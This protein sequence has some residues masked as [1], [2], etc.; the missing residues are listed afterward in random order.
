M[1]ASHPWRRWL[2]ALTMAATLTASVAVETAA[3]ATALPA[4]TVGDTYT[5]RRLYVDW[6]HSM[7]DT[8]YRLSAIYYPTDMVSTSNAGLSASYKVRKFV[9]RGSQGDGH[10]REGRR[11][12]VQHPVR[13]PQLRHAE[14]HVRLL[15][16]APWLRLRPQGERAGRPQRAPD[17]H[18]PGPQQLRRAGTV[19]CHRLGDDEGRQVARRERLEIRFH[20]VVPEGQDVADLLHVRAM[21]LPLRRADA[22]QA[23]ATAS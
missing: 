16:Q 10:G 19:G 7:L 15:G 20:P 6:A 22:G 12:Q 3:A 2:V 18:D 11:S 8:K 23:S 5:A 17:G 14:V 13:V 9:I 1:H 4:C 21:A